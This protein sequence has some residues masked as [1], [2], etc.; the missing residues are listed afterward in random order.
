MYVM[1][2]SPSFFLPKKTPSLAIIRI[3][4]FTESAKADL[5]IKLY[6]DFIKSLKENL[7]ETGCN[8][9]T[10]RFGPIMQVSLINDGPVTIVLERS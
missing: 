5:A 2:G 4:S 8:V 7:K 6:E 10:G 1:P 3:A 9:V